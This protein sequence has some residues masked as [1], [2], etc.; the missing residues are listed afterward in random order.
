MI[1]ALNTA[2]QGLLQAERRATDVAKDIL[3]STSEGASFSIDEGKDP[4]P[5]DTAQET[6]APAITGPSS[7]A[8]SGGDF[9]NLI[10]HFADLRAEE[11]AF[12][13]SA[14]AFNKIN[15]SLGTLLDDEG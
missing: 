4:L 8:P 1:K 3:K 10:Q 2:T 15:E 5:S 7:T 12:K 13:A 14:T 6:K 9:G 11:Q